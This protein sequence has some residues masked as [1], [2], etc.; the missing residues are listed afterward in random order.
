MHGGGDCSIF[1]L[2]NAIGKAFANQPDVRDAILG[3]LKPDMLLKK[4]ENKEQLVLELVILKIINKIARLGVNIK[5][6]FEGW[7]SDKN[8]QCKYISILD[9]FSGSRRDYGRT[10]THTGPYIRP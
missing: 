5:H 3:S 4:Q 2:I 9:S 10:E 6:V 7:D 1:D 8:N